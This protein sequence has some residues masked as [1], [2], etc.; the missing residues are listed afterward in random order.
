MATF[1]DSGEKADRRFIDDAT[2][3]AALEHAEGAPLVRD[4]DG[5]KVLGMTE[6]DTDFY[7]NVST[8]ERN[9]IKRKVCKVQAVAQ[10]RS[11]EPKTDIP[12]G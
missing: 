5:F 11:P 10:K 2:K 1:T 6:E 8:G 3:V 4:I 9:K 12:L 7:N